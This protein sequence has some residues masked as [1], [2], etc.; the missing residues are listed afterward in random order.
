MAERVRKVVRWDWGGSASSCAT[1]ALDVRQNR[2][3]SAGRSCA[4]S[5]RR[6]DIIRALVLGYSRTEGHVHDA[7]RHELLCHSEEDA[8]Q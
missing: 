4:I 7:K 3:P 1:S 8:A 5:R 6:P 2:P